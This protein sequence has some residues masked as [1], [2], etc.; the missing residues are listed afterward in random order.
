MYRMEGLGQ[1]SRN[2][3]LYRELCLSMESSATNPIGTRSER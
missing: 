3:K 1:E 2:W